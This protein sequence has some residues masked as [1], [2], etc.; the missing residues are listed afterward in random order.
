M[1]IGEGRE[2]EPAR[3]VDRLRVRIRV[4]SGDDEAAREGEFVRDVGGRREAG[5]EP[6]VLARLE[7]FG[8]DLV[9]LTRRYCDT[10]LLV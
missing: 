1:E 4:L 8:V 9:L 3:R 7:E 6:D 10:G 2:R 5:Q